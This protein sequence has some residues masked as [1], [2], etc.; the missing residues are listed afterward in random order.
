LCLIIRIDILSLFL[1]VAYRYFHDRTL[2]CCLI[3]AATLNSMML[4]TFSIYYGV[5]QIGEVI[6]RSTVTI[7]RGR[8]A[9]EGSAFYTSAS[10]AWPLALRKRSGRECAE[11]PWRAGQPP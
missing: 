1:S 11:E 10:V 9:P 3:Q 4:I 8:P 2:K 5:Y 7:G 6:A